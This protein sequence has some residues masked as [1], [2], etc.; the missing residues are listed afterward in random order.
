MTFE[1]LSVKQLERG[2]M[3]TVDALLT[4]VTQVIALKGFVELG[5]ASGFFYKSSDRLFLVTNKHVVIDEEK[6]YFPDALEIRVHTD[7][8]D[9]QKTRRIHLPLYFGHNKL[10]R[11]HSDPLVDIAVIDMAV[12]RRHLDLTDPLALLEVTVYSI[13]WFSAEDLL[14]INIQIGLGE[15]ALVLGFPYGFHDTVHNLPIVRAATISSPYPIR[16][17]SYPFFLIDARLH[18][19]TSGSPVILKPTNMLRDKDGNMDIFSSPVTFLLGI[20]S[21]SI[22]LPGVDDIDPLGLN[23]VWFANLIEQIIKE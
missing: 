4:A 7:W 6:D 15:D 11:E 21:A 8:G 9:I 10:W 12:E 20:H 14:P 5:T 16:F 2:E 18:P 3:A 13:R 1:L 22:R 23:A 17:R 19:G